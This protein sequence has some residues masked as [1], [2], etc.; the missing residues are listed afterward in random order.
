M[1]VFWPQTEVGWK[2]KLVH[3]VEQVLLYRTGY[4][5]ILV[6][7]GFLIDFFIHFLM[8]QSRGAIYKYIQ[9]HQNLIIFYGFW[10]SFHGESESIITFRIWLRNSELALILRVK[11][12]FCSSNMTSYALTV[13]DPFLYENKFWGPTFLIQKWS[14]KKTLQTLKVLLSLGVVAGSTDEIPWMHP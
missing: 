7:L 8:V 2:S 1:T 5:T 12:D 10:C 13:F 6:H 14:A 4:V 11:Y 3:V 9:M